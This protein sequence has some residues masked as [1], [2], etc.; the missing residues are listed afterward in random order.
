MSTTAALPPLSDIA[1][2]LKPDVGQ[3]I[4]LTAPQASYEAN[5]AGLASLKKKEEAQIKYQQDRS[6][7]LTGDLFNAERIAIKKL[8]ENKLKP[9]LS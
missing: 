2:H 4:E 9:L 7:S 6:A 8:I 3:V 1:S 5:L